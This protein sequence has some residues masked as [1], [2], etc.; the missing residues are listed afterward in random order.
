MS[1]PFVQDTVQKVKAE[2]GEQVETEVEPKE[3]KEVEKERLTAD[4]LAINDEQA[5]I[6]EKLEFVEIEGTKVIKI[7]YNQNFKLQLK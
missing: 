2:E 4:L 7:K 3:N 6:V 1:E 5:L